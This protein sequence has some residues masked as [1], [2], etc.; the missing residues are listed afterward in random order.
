MSRVRIVDNGKERGV[1]DSAGNSIPVTKARLTMV[2]DGPNTCELELVNLRDVDVW[3]EVVGL[4]IAG[5][6]SDLQQI[7]ESC[8]SDDDPESVIQRTAALA[9]DALDKLDLGKEQS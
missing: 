5:I 1:F 7:R 4:D 2:A 3:A 8:Y 9:G 6:R